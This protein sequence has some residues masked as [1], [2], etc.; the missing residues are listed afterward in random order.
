MINET[1]F[2]QNFTYD[3]KNWINMLEYRMYEQ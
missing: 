1:V 3:E 2:Y